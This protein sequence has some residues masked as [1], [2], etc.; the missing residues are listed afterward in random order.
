MQYNPPKEKESYRT[1]NDIQFPKQSCS[2]TIKPPPIFFLNKK[3]AVKQTSPPPQKYN[4]VK[5]IKK[6]KKWLKLN[7]NVK[8]IS[9]HVRLLGTQSM[10]IK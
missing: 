3:N 8:T 1:N 6:N 7:C 9:L 4:K 2:L 5:V 10:Y